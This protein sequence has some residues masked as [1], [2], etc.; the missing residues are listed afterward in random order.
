M[1]E[2][3]FFIFL[4]SLSL[5]FTFPNSK[6][7]IRSSRH[8]VT[9]SRV[10]PPLIWREKHPPSWRE[11]TP[12]PYITLLAHFSGKKPTAYPFLFFPQRSEAQGRRNRFERTMV[13]M[14]YDLLANPLGAVRLTFQKAVDSGHSG[15]ATLDGRDWGAADLFRQ[16]L[17]NDGGLSQVR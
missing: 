14:P 13:G 12:K 1:R 4:N 8:C 11:R 6:Q 2:R 9:G 10:S 17:F 5:H 3:L 16:F 15:A 7:S